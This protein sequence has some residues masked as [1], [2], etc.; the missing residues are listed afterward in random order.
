MKSKYQIKKP[1]VMV[2]DDQPQQ[3]RSLFTALQ[4]KG[5]NLL[6]AQSGAEALLLLEQARP[7]VILLDVSLPDLDGFEVCQRIKK[8]PNVSDIPVLFITASIQLLDKLEGLR[9][10]GADYITKPFQLE[11]V[12]ARV[13]THLTLRRLQ[14][15]LQEEKERFKA[16]ANAAFEGIILSVDE[17][18]IDVN[19]PLEQMLGYSRK[20]ILSKTLS[21]IFQKKY[22]KL[23]K[24]LINSETEYIKEVSAVRKQGEPVSLEI[25]CRTIV[26][27]GQN[28]R[29]VAL[30]DIT[31]QKKLE[32]QARKLESENIILK[33][34]RNDREHLGELV[35]RGPVMQI[36]YERILKAALSN[37]PVMI[38]GETGSGKELAARTIWQLDQ[39]YGASFIAV[40]CAALQETLFESQFFGHRKGAFTGAVQDTLGFFSQARGGVLF[41]DEVT[42][43]T[44][45]MQ[46]KLLRVLNSGE[47]TPLGDSKPCMA[48]SR[49]IAATNQE[50]RSLITLGQF[51]EDLFYRL[52]VI[53]LEM[54]PLRRHK[55]D[56]PLLVSHFLRQKLHGNAAFSMPSESLMARFREY[57][58]PGNVRELS[59]ELRRYV[60][61]NEVELGVAVPIQV[62]KKEISSSASL[63]DRMAAFERQVI[64]ESLS[65]SEGNRNRAAELLKIPLP[66][67][68][69]KIQKYLL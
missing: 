23:I 29:V 45:S 49:I 7:D 59:N 1:T 38:Y 25:Q 18:I 19:Q 27:Q 24:D 11:E 39:K 44:A 30:R 28:V 57:D 66:T 9:S 58:W 67:L 50:L 48:D 43:L 61:M 63:S 35:G 65:I 17:T 37:A 60:S 52:H 41:L 31:Q 69:R 51:R 6:I 62:T 36:V 68:Y 15:E 3:L 64:S 33:A 5:F 54:P 55:E 34:S 12:V 46:A 10:G 13:K 26:H 2:V 53:S 40:N 22:L 47:Y 8:L 32:A 4:D 14:L 16:L 56:L 42:E 21:E 20:E